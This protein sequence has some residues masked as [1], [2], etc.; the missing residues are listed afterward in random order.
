MYYRIIVNPTA[1]RGEAEL[2]VPRIERLLRDQGLD[3]ELIRTERPWHAAELAQEAAETGID[4]VVAVG[5]DGTANEVING[6]MQI[7]QEQ[8]TCALSVLCL[9]GGNDFAFGAGIPADLEEGVRV[10]AEGYRRTIDVGHVVGGDYPH[11][12]YFGNG[13]GVGFDAVVGFVAAKLKR[14]HGFA[15]YI[16]ATLK[17]VFIYYPAPMVTLEYEDAVTGEHQTRRLPALMVSVMN[18]RRMGGGFMMA[19]D[20]SPS[21]GLFDLCIARQVSRLGVFGLVPH[22]LRGTQATQ[23]AITTGRTSRLIVSAAEE[24]LPA[25]ADGET[26]CTA[27]RKLEISLIPQQIHVICREAPVP[28]ESGD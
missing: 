10:L 28:S 12:R 14:L 6:L 9:G 27:G 25:H 26:L 5:G 22:F 13:I 21:D 18:G 17:T 23:E 4:V 19:P 20:G 1:G 24:T 7:P 15:G 8:R 11:G 3:Y 2:A 16:V